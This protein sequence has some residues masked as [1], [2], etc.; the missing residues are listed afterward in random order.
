MG[1]V[2]YSL[3][4]SPPYSEASAPIEVDQGAGTVRFGYPTFLA[5]GSKPP[6]DVRALVPIWTG[7]NLAVY[8]ADIAGVPQYSGN[9]HTVEG[10]SQTLTVTVRAWRDPANLTAMTAYASDLL[11]SVKDPIVEGNVTYYGL[12]TPALTPGIALSIAGNGYTTGWESAAVAVI[13]AQI[14]WCTAPG[15]P[16]NYVTTMRCSSRRAH[17]TDAAFAHPDRTG[18]TF[19]FGN[20]INFSGATS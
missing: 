11:D 5:A 13:E 15:Q 2:C 6:D 4:H 17:F 7:V 10:L 12:Y 9:T 18:V 8:P 20:R 19:D 16:L 1:T 3:S 14:E